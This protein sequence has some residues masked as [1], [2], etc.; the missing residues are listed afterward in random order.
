MSDET[1]MAE[2]VTVARQT[3]AALQ[4]IL[5]TQPELFINLVGQPMIVL[6]SAGEQPSSGP[7]P[8]RSDRVKAWFAEVVWKQLRVVLAEREI[9]RIIIVLV[10][11]AWHDQRTNIAITEAIEQDPLLDVLLK[12][13]L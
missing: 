10:G 6:P 7:W 11:R 3:A 13:S 8:L 5:N 4:L 12:C 1:S 9:D 2:S